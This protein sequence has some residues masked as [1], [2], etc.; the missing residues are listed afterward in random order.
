MFAALLEELAFV[1]PDVFT[2]SDFGVG[3]V[4]HIVLYRF[5]PG[6]TGRRMDEILDR[7]L[8]LQR[9]ARR[10]GRPYIVSIDGGYQQ[11]GERQ[12]AGFQLG[13]VVTFASLG[14]RNFFV[15]RP[16]LRDGVHAD[17]AF[18]AFRASIAPFLDDDGTLVFDLVP[19]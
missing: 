8:K 7:F 2:A 19:Q 14:D 9:D 15:G 12:G 5:K 13:F 1:G 10:N 6:L 11:S 18:A 17:P 4:R 16:I 3:C